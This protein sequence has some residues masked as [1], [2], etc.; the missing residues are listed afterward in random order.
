MK[1]AVTST[2][3]TLES[4]MDSRFGRCKYFLFVDTEN[5]QFEAIENANGALGGGA[6]IQAARLMAERGV[7]A[8]LTGNLG[9]NAHETLSAAGIDSFTGLNGTV[10]EGIAQYLSGAMSTATGPSVARHNGMN[11]ER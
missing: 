3:Q 2:G 6:G 10:S 1:L 7:R 8:V 4:Q 5:M 9:P 11:A